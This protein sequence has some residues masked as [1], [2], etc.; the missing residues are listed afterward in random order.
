[1]LSGQQPSAGKGKRRGRLP[2]LLLIGLLAAV[3]L[4]I[5]MGRPGFWNL[6]SPLTHK[7]QLYHLAGH[8]KVDPLLLAAIVRTE[9]TFNP[10]AQS[11]AGA[12][13][14][15][16]L[17]PDT[18][19]QAADKLRLDYDSVDDLYRDDI[20]LRLGTY[21]FARLLKSFHGDTILALA[22]YNA[23]AAKVRTW[24]LPGP[25]APEDDRLDAIPLAETRDYV[26]RVLATHR[27]FKKVQRLKRALQELT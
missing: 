24:S 18:A 19:Q 27:F 9:S 25:G 22:A 21:H 23:G 8:Y 11:R 6:F 2:F 20:N 1:V 17:M 10:F 4:L 16:Q 12:V 13:G 5:A 26:S 3:L 14:L 15:M 7:D